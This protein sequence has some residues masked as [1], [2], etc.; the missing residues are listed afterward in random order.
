MVGPLRPSALEI[1]VFF[2]KKTDIFFLQNSSRV[3]NL[4]HYVSRMAVFIALVLIF[5]AVRGSDGSEWYKHGS[6]QLRS[7]LGDFLRIDGNQV[8][9]DGRSNASSS[10]YNAGADPEEVKWV[11]CHPPFLSPFFLFFLSLKYLNNI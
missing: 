5:G 11:N 7:A 3:N 2:T 6:T 8:K 1:T 4:F 10:K 9:S